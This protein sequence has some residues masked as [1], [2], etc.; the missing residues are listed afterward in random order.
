MR[1]NSD[2]EPKLVIAWVDDEKDKVE[3]FTRALGE[4]EYGEITPQKLSQICELVPI[5][6]NIRKNNDSEKLVQ[7]VIEKLHELSHF[8]D[9]V[10]V[11]VNIGDAS[12]TGPKRA[13]NIGINL[14]LD[15]RRQIRPATPVGMYTA[16][17]L[18]SSDKVRISSLCFAATL[19][20]ILDLV[21]G[22]DFLTGD[23]WY[24]LFRGIVKRAQE[25]QTELPDALSLTDDVQNVV[26]AED[27]P[28]SRSLSFMR[29]APKL[30]VRALEY[31][32]LPNS[33]VITISQLSGGFSGSYLLK[34]D[35]SEGQAS[36]V[37]KI[38]EDPRKLVREL[39]GYRKVM[40]LL[41]FNH[42]LPVHDFKP[43]GLTEEWW[44]AFAIPYD[45]DAKPLLEQ[46]DISGMEL[47]RLYKTLW[48]EC[49]C[50]L[51]GSPRLEALQYGQVLPETLIGLAQEGWDALDRY[52]SEFSSLFPSAYDSTCDLLIQLEKL[53]DHTFKSYSVL[54]AWVEQVHGDLNCRN[55]LYNQQKDTF[56][57]I[58]FP[59]VGPP[60]CVAYDFVK[61][62]AELV[63]IMLDWASGKDYD[64]KRIE[65]WDELLTECLNDFIPS[66][67]IFNNSELDRTLV[68]IRAIR[69]TYQDTA[70]GQGQVELSYNLYLISRVM[71]YLAYEDLTIAKRFLA[72]IWTWRLFKGL[73]M[74]S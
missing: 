37:I 2:E 17:H 4:R 62:E 12:L 52:K 66:S 54:V 64:I 9:I 25:R 35:L 14:A 43:V 13:A 21:G 57:I 23:E 1:A 49:L 27:N 22:G 51:Y 61:A 19:E 31:L 6:I 42:Y 58:D 44:G 50:N 34:A 60:N 28:P 65:S 48:N 3:K 47:A 71:R 11:D 74:L 5:T 41:N 7:S 56:R 15:L 70:A 69:E 33:S 67:R 26:W 73:R 53:R 63:L 45:G 36:F 16:F 20:S 30:V 32:R 29:A 40:A 68:A 39:D 38:D 10:F 59:N 18:K 55:I 72:F 8:P 24:R 46:S